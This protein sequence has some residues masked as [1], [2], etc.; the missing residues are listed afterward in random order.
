MTGKAWA[1]QRADVELRL[2]AC[3]ATC[4]I[5]LLFWLYGSGQDLSSLF[6]TNRDF[7]NYWIASKL[8]MEGHVLDLFSG[9]DI[10]FARMQ[11]VFGQDYPWHNWSYPPHYLLLVLPFGLLP[12]VASGIV[13]QL[14][15]L[16]LFLHAA[17]LARA[18]EARGYWLLLLPFIVCNLHLS[19]NG[20]LTAALMLYGLS[21]RFRRP[22]LAGVAIGLLTIKPQLGLL[23]PILLLLERRWQTIAAAALSAGLSMA[24][25]ALLF[26]VDTWTGYV[27]HNL[28]YQTI[29]MTDFGG[30]FLHLMPSV[31]GA[32]R[33]LDLDAATAMALHLPVAALAIV[34]FLYLAWR[35]ETPEARSLSLLFATFCIAPYSLLYDLGALCVLAAAENARERMLPQ[36]QGRRWRML[37]LAAVCL[38]PVLALPFSL[39]GLPIAPAV[40]LLGWAAAVVPLPERKAVNA[41]PPR[42]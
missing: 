29:V 14:A 5:G 35:L 26:G 7:A 22:L 37:M 11:E 17:S 21:L 33:S 13:F 19:Q 9:Q 38:L 36:G 2:F 10:Y 1:G 16:A 6:W 32:A 3:L 41:A 39:A 40:L 23:L 34:A 28:P 8:A 42:G 12:Y 18:P 27:G 20:F 25:S 4:A 31:Y 30:F 24:L 15:T